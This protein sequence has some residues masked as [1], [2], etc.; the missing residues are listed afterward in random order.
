L[1]LGVKSESEA[2]VIDYVEEEYIDDM[3]DEEATNDGF[4]NEDGIIRT[5]DEEEVSFEQ[6]KLRKDSSKRLSGTKESCARLHF[7]KLISISASPS[8]SG[9]KE[10]IRRNFGRQHFSSVTDDDESKVGV[11]D[12]LHQCNFCS[13]ISLTAHEHESHMAVHEGELQYNCKKCDDKFPTKEKAREHLTSAHTNDDKAFNCTQCFKTFKNRYQLIL[14]T[15]S[16]TGEKPFPCP[17]CNRCF[18]MSSN[19]QKHLV[20]I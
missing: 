19:L 17:I 2:N 5:E 8:K 15:R 1:D 10:K 13:K 4:E 6:T 9:V 14:H 20:S 16:H 18:S 11:K 7:F 12:S 3:H